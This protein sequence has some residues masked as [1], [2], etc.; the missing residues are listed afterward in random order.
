MS[1]LS[2][3]QFNIERQIMSLGQGTS[4]LD[5]RVRGIQRRTANV[6]RPPFSTDFRTVRS[7]KSPA[8]AQPMRQ[9]QEQDEEEED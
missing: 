2:G 5:D 3:Q 9:A 1:D 7:M 6:F 8:A 4:E